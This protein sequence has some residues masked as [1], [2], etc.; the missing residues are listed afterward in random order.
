MV[1]TVSSY[2]RVASYQELVQM[3]PYF[4]LAHRLT[5]G[6]EHRSDDLAEKN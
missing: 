6:K 3:Q 2:G 1:F 5:L 4:L